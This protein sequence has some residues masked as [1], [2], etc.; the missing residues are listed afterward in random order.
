MGRDIRAIA[1]LAA[2][3]VAPGLARRE[4]TYVLTDEDLDDIV[5]GPSLPLP[6]RRLLPPRDHIV[7]PKPLSKR[8]RRR[9][10]GKAKGQPHA[11]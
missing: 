11:L 6:M 2:L 9:L 3:A 5:E 7:T 4:H 10:R 8:A 1:A